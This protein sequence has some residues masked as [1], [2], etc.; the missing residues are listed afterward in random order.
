[1]RSEKLR[2]F[3][4]SDPVARNYS[5]TKQRE[6]AEIEADVERFLAQGGEIQECGSEANRNPQFRPGAMVS[7]HGGLVTL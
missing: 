2:H 1:M 3:P 6:R 7:R 4:S 5:E